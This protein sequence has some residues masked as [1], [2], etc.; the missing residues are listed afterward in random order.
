M[1]NISR[2][3]LAQ[4][5]TK[6]LLAGQSARKVAKQLAAILIESKKSKDAG[7]LAKDIAWELECRGKLAQ[8]QVTSAVGLSDLLRKELLSFVKQAAKVDQVN[9]QE[10]VDKS[11]IGGVYI[12]TAAHAWNKTIAK[13]LTD[14]REAF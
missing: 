3:R 10:R 14:I 7:L 1:I 5:A 6:Q 9:L 4:Y 2:R 13:Q 12:E 8:A 11:V